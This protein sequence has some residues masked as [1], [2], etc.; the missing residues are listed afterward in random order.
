VSYQTPSGSS[1]I[2]SLVTNSKNI[3]AGNTDGEIKVWLGE[4]IDENNKEGK[5]VYTKVKSLHGKGN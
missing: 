1:E 2:L 3:Y 5:I 4:S